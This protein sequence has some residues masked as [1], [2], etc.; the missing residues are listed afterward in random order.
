MSTSI[1]D[2][3]KYLAKM[4]ESPY[5][6]ML[7]NKLVP[8]DPSYLHEVEV[9]RA[10]LRQEDRQGDSGPGETSTKSVGS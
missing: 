9:L 4:Y 8:L 3:R 1:R 6:R 2:L 7:K 10:L 5:I